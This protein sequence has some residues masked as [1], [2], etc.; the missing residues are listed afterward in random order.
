MGQTLIPLAEL[1][2]ITLAKLDEIPDNSYNFLFF[3]SST[4]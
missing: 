1:P 2:I 3:F 4:K